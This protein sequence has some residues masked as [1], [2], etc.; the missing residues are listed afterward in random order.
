M[1][2]RMIRLI[3]LVMTLL[4]PSLVWAQDV[5]SDDRYKGYPKELIQWPTAPPTAEQIKE[6][7]AQEFY[8]PADYHLEKYAGRLKVASVR[9]QET[10]ECT[11]ML[12]AHSDPAKRWR[13]VMR[14]AGTKVAQDKYGR[15]LF[16]LGSPTGKPCYNPRPLVV[17]ILPVV[18]MVPEI[19]VPPALKLREQIETGV[20]VPKDKEPEVVAPVVIVPPAPESHGWFCSGKK[21]IFCAAAVACIT[22]SAIN[23]SPFC[24]IK[25]GGSKPTPPNTPSGRPPTQPTPPPN[26]TPV[27]PG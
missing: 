21:G 14:P 8:E 20:Y 7:Q 6:C 19:I 12:T 9:I 5:T 17:K 26:T 13:W 18:P 1:E 11:W 15:D 25:V 3:V 16:D 23:R 27:K 2:E 24:G 10:S 22:G 4:A